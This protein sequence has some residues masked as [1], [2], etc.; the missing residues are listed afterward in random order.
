MPHTGPSVPSKGRCGVLNSELTAA[1]VD[2][3]N[4]KLVAFLSSF[5][6]PSAGKEHLLLC[7]GHLF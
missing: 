4:I 1:S 3:P 5:P 2:L 6:P 7:T